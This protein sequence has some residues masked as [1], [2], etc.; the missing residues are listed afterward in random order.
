MGRQARGRRWI[1]AAGVVL[2]GALAANALGDA[3]VVGVEGSASARRDALL[4][5]GLYVPLLVFVPAWAL[6]RL[7]RADSMGGEQHDP[8]EATRG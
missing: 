4:L 2:V 1:V 6:S 7:L 8:P 3:G 5:F